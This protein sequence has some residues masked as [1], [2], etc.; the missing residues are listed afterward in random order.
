MSEEN[1]QEL[2]V[3]DEGLDNNTVVNW[4][5]K[6]KELEAQNARLLFESK[7]HKTRHDEVEQLR[8]EIELF[9]KQK[10]EESGSLEEKLQFKDDENR[11]L[12]ESYEGLRKQTLR[13]NVFNAISNVAKDA[14][15]VNDL[16]NQPEF[17]NMI[18]VEEGSLEPTQESVV[19]FVNTLREKKDYMFA[20]KKL[21]PMGD[22]NPTISKPVIK[23]LAQMSREELADIRRAKL[24]TI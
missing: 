11:K 10:L 1:K 2:A 21:A 7:K 13:A 16:I 23:P 19:S 4:E 17:M 24:K 22:A 6:V 20:G 5:S 8:G 12:Q 9:K 14:R 3:N 18:E 15:D